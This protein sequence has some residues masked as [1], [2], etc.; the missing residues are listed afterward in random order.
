MYARWGIYKFLSP[1]TVDKAIRIKHMHHLCFVQY[2]FPLSLY[3]FRSSAEIPVPVQCPRASINGYAL[4]TSLSSCV[5]FIYLASHA[6]LNNLFPYLDLVD[7]F[8]S[9]TACSAILIYMYIMYTFLHAWS[10]FRSRLR[11]F[12]GWMTCL[13]CFLFQIW[14]RRS[15]H[16]SLIHQVRESIMV[17]VAI[18]EL[19]MTII[20]LLHLAGLL[21]LGCW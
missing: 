10:V 2:N 13:N 5:L 18:V 15:E 9:F 12:G 17:V 7:M 3:L 11:F 4:N 21:S 14:R 16:C 20:M 1:A 6:Y 8:D 19:K